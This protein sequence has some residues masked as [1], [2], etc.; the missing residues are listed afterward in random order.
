MTSID[1]VTLEVTDVAA[2][3]AFTD[4]DGLVWEAAGAGMRW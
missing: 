2:A 1:S 3:E 4:P